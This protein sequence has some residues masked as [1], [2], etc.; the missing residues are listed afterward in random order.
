MKIIANGPKNFIT[1]V[2][3]CRNSQLYNIKITNVTIVQSF[4]RNFR[5]DVR[6]SLAHSSELFTLQFSWNC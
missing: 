1:I 2:K 5:I 3:M 6:I 4:I